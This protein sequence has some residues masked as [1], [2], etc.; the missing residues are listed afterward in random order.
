MVAWVLEWSSG[1]STELWLGYRDGRDAVRLAASDGSYFDDLTFSLDGD[2]LFFLVPYWVVSPQVNWADLETFE[3]HGSLVGA[4]QMRIVPRGRYAGLLA[5]EQGIIKGEEIRMWYWRLH[6]T[7]LEF[8]EEVASEG[9][10]D[11][12]AVEHIP[13]R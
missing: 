6:T 5:L 9:G 10:Y 3:V 8:V 12:W 7:D 2:R 1:D 4:T 13:P 11:A